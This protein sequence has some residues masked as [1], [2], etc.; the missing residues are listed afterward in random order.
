MH[1]YS[2]VC[3]TS[4][5]YWVAY[6]SRGV[7]CSVGVVEFGSRLVSTLTQLE[8][9]YTVANTVVYLI[10]SLIKES[11]K[12]EARM[13]YQLLHLVEFRAIFVMV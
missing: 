12:V 4:T 11:L 6:T 2:H 13:F 10:S 5:E 3:S 8:I 7:T 1:D 9:A